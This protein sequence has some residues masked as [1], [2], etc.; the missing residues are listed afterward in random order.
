MIIGN[1][2]IS[3]KNHYIFIKKNRYLG[4][5]IYYFFQRI[6]MYLLQ[7]TLVVLASQGIIL[8]NIQRC[9]HVNK[10]QLGLII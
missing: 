1:I 8:K 7:D 9:Y 2:H 5:V 6:K 4:S 10:S 3:F